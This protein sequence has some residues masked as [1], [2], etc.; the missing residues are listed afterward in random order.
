MENAPGPRRASDNV[1]SATTTMLALDTAG[2]CARL[3]RIAA[4]AIPQTTGVNN[5]R[6]NMLSRRR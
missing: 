1:E 4:I 3:K 2:E 5:P 6:H